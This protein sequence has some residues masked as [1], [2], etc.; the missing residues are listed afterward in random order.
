M[1]CQLS[2]NE[3]H[4]DVETPDKAVKTARKS[5]ARTEVGLL[6]E[7]CNSQH[8]LHEKVEF[9]RS[10]IQ[11]RLEEQKCDEAISLQRGLLSTALRSGNKNLLSGEHIMLADVLLLKGESSGD[12]DKLKQS[13]EALRSAEG[14]GV[15]E[16]MR[17]LLHLTRAHVLF[18][19]GCNSYNNL[20]QRQIFWQKAVEQHSQAKD[21]FDAK[22]SE[23]AFQHTTRLK[24]YERRAE[25]LGVAQK[26]WSGAAE[27]LHKA[28][29]TLCE[30]DPSSWV[31]TRIDIYKS[32][33]FV[34]ASADD[35]SSPLLPRSEDRLLGSVGGNSEEA[36]ISLKSCEEWTPSIAENEASPPVFSMDADASV[37]LQSVPTLPG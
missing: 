35:T 36:D 13:E 9:F 12:D 11:K 5:S 28:A 8:N 2:Q 17:L 25:F 1:G 7:P 20:P 30:R 16:G 34:E 4:P 18:L 10:R 3:T 22:E 24:L 37:S 31:E 21:V 23:L 14:L 33:P 27:L 19:R 29:V 26:D 15:P 32:S 6:R